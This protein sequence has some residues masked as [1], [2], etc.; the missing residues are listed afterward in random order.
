MITNLK[1]R[2]SAVSEREKRLGVKISEKK[3]EIMNVDGK[4]KEV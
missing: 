3:I 2:E 1:A 4:A